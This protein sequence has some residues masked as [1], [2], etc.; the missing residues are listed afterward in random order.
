MSGNRDFP[1]ETYL[2]GLGRVAPISPRRLRGRTRPE[3]DVHEMSV[4]AANSD[5]IASPAGV[6]ATTPVA[7]LYWLAKTNVEGV[8]VGTISTD[9]NPASLSQAR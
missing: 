6:F 9:L 1:I 7:D 2:A 5:G 8:D 4:D 3:A